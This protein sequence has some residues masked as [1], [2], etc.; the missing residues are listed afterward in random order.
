[1]IKSILKIFIP[2]FYCV[3]TNKR[4]NSYTMGCPPVLGNNQRALASGLPYVGLHVKNHGMTIRSYGVLQN[5][6][7]RAKVGKGGINK[8][9]RTEFCCLGHAPGVGL[10]GAWGI[11][12][13]TWSSGISN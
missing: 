4:S 11:F 13:R 3:V 2:N 10:G 5:K 9:Y 1:M 7:V 6:I 8:T 12:F